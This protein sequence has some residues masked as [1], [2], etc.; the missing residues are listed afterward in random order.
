MA[1]PDSDSDS[2]GSFGAELEA[3]LLRQ[4][5]S[6]PAEGDDGGSAKRRKLSHGSPHGEAPQDA[7]V[8]PPGAAQRARRGAAAC[9]GYTPL[10]TPPVLSRLPRLAAVEDATTQ[11]LCPPHPGFLGGICIRCGAHRRRDSEEEDGEDGEQQHVSLSCV[12]PA[13][14]FLRLYVLPILSHTHARA[15]VPV[16]RP[17]GAGG[18]GEPAAQRRAEESACPAQAAAHPGPGPHAAELGTDHRRASVP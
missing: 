9:D 7:P 15:Q 5:E 6:P 3:E 2:L 18:G 17:G 16:R 12:L 4:Q 8:P 13:L 11:K 14:A 1:T 10:H